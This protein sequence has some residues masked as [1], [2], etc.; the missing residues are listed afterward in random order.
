MILW[1][2]LPPLILSAKAILRDLC[3]K[4]LNWDD[5]IPHEDLV[6]W[7]DWLKELSKLEQFAVERC[8]KPTNFGLIVSSQLHSFSDAS[9][10]GYGVVSYLRVVN[11][12]KDVHC[13]FLIGTSRQ[14]PQKSITIPRL[15]LSAAV[16][17]TRLN[18]MMQNELDVTVDR[19]F[20][21]TDSTCVLSYIVNKDKRF[22][23]FVANRITTT[24]EG[25]R[26]DQWY[27]VDT[28]SNLLTTRLG[29]SPLK[30]VYPQKPLDRWPFLSLGS[31]GLL[32]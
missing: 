9:G 1:G 5:R 6:R 23:T 12:A 17:A 19:E 7:Q 15:E 28:C 18:R 22:Q 11:E 4:G 8:L 14:T 3:R 29:D 21:W 16:V 2:S 20:F 27:Y 32:A 10:E 26:Q 30:R 24:H 25:S 13:A 31:R